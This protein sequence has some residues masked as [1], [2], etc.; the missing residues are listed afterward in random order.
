MDNRFIRKIM[1][2]AMTLIMLIAFT[3]CGKGEDV[4]KLGRSSIEIKKNGNV[5][6]TIV[7]DFSESYYD[8]AELR[9]MTE[10]EINAF[11][12]ANGEGAAELDSVESE[13][14]KVRMVIKFGNA[15][16]FA[17]FNSE[18]L[19]Y[20][21]VTDA[22]L[23]GRMDASNLLD[24]NGNPADAEKAAALVNEHVVVAS[25]NY[26]ISLPYKIK[27]VSPGVKV[28]DKYSVDLSET[29]EG[30]VVCIVLNK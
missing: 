22:I 17:Q 27:Y 26:V 5:V 29:A 28:I 11:I 2:C 3:G 24:T 13:D 21:T 4:S 12:V 9:E 6:N 16:N 30:S 19:A 18:T 25:G 8:T 7:E 1:A 15:D 14:G 20:E 10:N 23:T